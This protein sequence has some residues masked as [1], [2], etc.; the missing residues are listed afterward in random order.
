MVRYALPSSLNP[1]LT[2]RQEPDE[3]DLSECSQQSMSFLP[4]PEDFA[5]RSDEDG[6]SSDTV[7]GDQQAGTQKL[8]SAWIR[9][10]EPL[11]TT[12]ED[13]EEASHDA[14]HLG[15]EVNES[16]E[17]EGSQHSRSNKPG[18]RSMTKSHSRRIR[19][20]SNQKANN[21]NGRTS[22]EL[23]WIFAAPVQQVQMLSSFLETHFPSRAAKAD[24]AKRN[25]YLMALP[26]IDLSKSP[27]L[28]HALDTI[29]FAHVGSKHRDERLQRESQQSYGKVLT[30]LVADL[31]RKEP[32]NEPRH[33]LASILLLCLYDD[34][35]PSPKSLLSGWT[36][37]Y[38]GAQ[39][40]LKA[41]GP[42]ALNMAD[43]FDRLT[44][45]NM[46]APAIYL[47]IARRK[48]TVL[49]LPQ[50]LS[51]A[52]GAPHAVPSRVKMY[53]EALQIPSLL[54]RTE[55]SV[56]LKGKS[57]DLQQLCQDIHD[58]QGRLTYW[59]RNISTVSKRY[60]GLNDHLVY[61][62]DAGAF[63]IN[64]EEQCFMTT[65]STFA[66]FYDVTPYQSVEDF[67]LYWFFTLVLECALLRLLHFHPVAASYL[68]HRTPDDVE[69][70]ALGHATNLCRIVLS[71]SKYYTD[72]Q[73]HASH[74]DC[75]TGLA[76]N[77][78]DEVGAVQEFAWCQAFR[79]ALRLRLNRL[80]S[81]Q[82]RTLCRMGDIAEDVSAVA[83]FKTRR[84]RASAE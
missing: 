21:S 29:C 5:L 7:E 42:H 1:I 79:L 67:T 37:H 64:F 32:R 12:A 10:H 81:N 3:T 15:E 39:Q 36:A 58:L 24:L 28:R 50:W 69:R 74:V 9:G 6:G 43:A 53:H 18:G 45:A 14:Y 72:S 76:Q 20:L 59:L 48:A 23:T 22:T 19:H 66:S 26:D 65:N 71:N 54:E 17:P 63:D 11:W 2:S 30:T 4:H 73:G 77:F 80:K 61:I 41:V 83:L 70:D 82:P 84:L 34:S 60:N 62:T 57:P 33:I 38:H 27:I 25:S 31:N 16:S 52:G 55:N 75:F 44:F 40:F 49:A 51:L 13:E 35:I 46:R 78:F 47:G 56:R 8:N 68:P